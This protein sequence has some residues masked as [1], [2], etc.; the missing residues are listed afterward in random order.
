[1]VT[2]KKGIMCAMTS[3][4]IGCGT[5]VSEKEEIIP[6][7]DKSMKEIYEEHS[8][9]SST[10]N[11]L[12]NQKLVVKRPATS[13]EMTINVYQYNNV[14]KRPTFKRLPNPTLYIYFAPSLSKDGRLPIPAWMTEFQMYDK[15]E[16]ALPGE[17]NMEA[18]R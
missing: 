10:A 13:E 8:T 14:E 16:Y 9:S 7:S 18:T 15:D 11:T 1:M 3:V 4:L 6:T 12:S 5:T 2:I 17:L